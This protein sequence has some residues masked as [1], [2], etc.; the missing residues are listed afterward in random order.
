M[1]LAEQA[2]TDLHRGFGPDTAVDD[3]RQVWNRWL[4][5][6]RSG[7]GEAGEGTSA[8]GRVASE[9][10]MAVIGQIFTGPD[11]ALR[12][13]AEACRLRA[14]RARERFTAAGVE[15]AGREADLNRAKVAFG[16]A[17]R[18]WHQA[19]ASVSTIAQT[20]GMSEDA[21]DDVVGTLRNEYEPVLACGFC[22]E[23]RARRLIAGPG[24]YI[25]SECVELAQ[26][27]GA[28]GPDDQATSTVSESGRCSFCTRTPDQV[29]FMAAS[30]TTLICD[31]CLDL[32]AEILEENFEV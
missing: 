5:L 11:A 32:C 1:E 31:D 19:G 3:A 15:M 22:M 10:I 30:A 9:L 17:I 14:E 7:S 24:V 13:A 8:A 28:G 27:V 18:R 4:Q 23:R 29:R 21:V 6:G 16:N 25:C 20:I 26:R 12:E 2:V